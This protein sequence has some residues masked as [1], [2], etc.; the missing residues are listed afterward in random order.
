[1]ADP[2]IT[3]DVDPFYAEPEFLIAVRPMAVAY[4]R[5]K[6]DYN[7]TVLAKGADG[8]YREV[9]EVGEAKALNALLTDAARVIR[10]GTAV[11]PERSPA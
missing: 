4:S 9:E 5:E 8:V 1:M 3:F 10:T 2:T 6:P 11:L 7:V